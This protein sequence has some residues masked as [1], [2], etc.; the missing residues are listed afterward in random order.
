MT[1]DKVKEVANSYV[2]RLR[3]ILTID[4][5]QLQPVRVSKDTSEPDT[6]TTLQHVLWMCEEIPNLVDA[7]RIEK[8]M[9]WLGFVQ[10]C[11]WQIGLLTI[12]DLKENNKPNE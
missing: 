1:G 8:S 10:G 4:Y 6:A 3:P 12:G 5:D 2:N 11:L 9:R 7:G